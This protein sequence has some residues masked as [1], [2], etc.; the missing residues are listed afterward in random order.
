MDMH[1]SLQRVAEVAH[2]HVSGSPAGCASALVRLRRLSI[3][4]YTRGSHEE[5]TCC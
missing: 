3:A 5:D 2:G 4:P 1:P